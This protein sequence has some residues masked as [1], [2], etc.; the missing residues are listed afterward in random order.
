MRGPDTALAQV[1]RGGFGD[2]GIV[3]KTD[4]SIRGVTPLFALPE[5]IGQAEERGITVTFEHLKPEVRRTGNAGYQRVG[6]SDLIRDQQV[7]LAIDLLLHFL[8]SFQGRIFP[9]AVWL[10]E[11]NHEKSISQHQLKHLPLQT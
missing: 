8:Q 1:E 5:F 10:A 11:R 2:M 4:M 3:V 6:K 7:Q 9:Q